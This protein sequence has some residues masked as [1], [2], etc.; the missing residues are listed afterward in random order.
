MNMP[1]E[2]TFAVTARWSGRILSV[3]LICTMAAFAIG[4]GQPQHLREMALGIA[5]W[6]M[7][8]GLVLAWKWEG[9]GG[10]LILGGFAAFAIVNGGL[11]INWHNPLLVLLD[12]PLLIFPIAGLLFLFS[13]WNK[14]KER[15]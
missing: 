8:Q 1:T 7:L 10:C 4:E 11:R 12:N 15:R 9:L 14:Y 2:R 5:L 6:T 13:W 3:F